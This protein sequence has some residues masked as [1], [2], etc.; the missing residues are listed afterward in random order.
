MGNKTIL[1]DKTYY[2]RKVDVP[3]LH[4][5][6]GEYFQSK[7]QKLIDT[8]PNTWVAVQRAGNWL[9]VCFR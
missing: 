8:K 3:N 4:L 5:T 2:F 7:V 9:M 6:Y 1:R